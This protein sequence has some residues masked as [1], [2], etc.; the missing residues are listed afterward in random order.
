M[1]PVLKR[2]RSLSTVEEGETVRITGIEGG[3]IV[4]IRLREM[5]L[6][7]GNTIEVIQNSGG[8]VIIQNGESR[9]ALGRGVSSKI[10]VE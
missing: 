5:G 1:A 6:S 9:L 7:P 2:P 10:T 4:K 3:R 8:P